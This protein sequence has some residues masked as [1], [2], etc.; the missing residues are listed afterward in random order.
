MKVKYIYVSVAF[1]KTKNKKM[2]N[3]KSSAAIMRG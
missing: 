1:E 3:I 2:K